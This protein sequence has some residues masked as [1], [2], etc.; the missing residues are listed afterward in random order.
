MQTSSLRSVI[1]RIR[2]T[3][4][5]EVLSETLVSY[6]NFLSVLLGSLAAQRWIAYG[7]LLMKD[8]PKS[9]MHH[10]R[11]TGMPSQQAISLRERLRTRPASPNTRSKN[12]CD[13]RRT[14]SSSTL[15]IARQS[16]WSYSPMISQPRKGIENAV[17]AQGYT[18]VIFVYGL[19]A[20][21][22]DDSGDSMRLI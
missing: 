20:I 19:T 2:N 4:D 7:R 11:Q 22:G 3:P 16:V 13:S 1:H 14:V 12:G 8:G 15:G 18:D 17:T 10:R 5:F 9:S 21:I 6:A